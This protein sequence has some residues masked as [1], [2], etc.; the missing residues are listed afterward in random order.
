MT[1]D[2]KKDLYEKTMALL[3]PVLERVASDAAFRERLEQAPLAVLDELG[4]TIDSETRA[5]LE[6]K[7][8][9]EFWAARRRSVEGPVE[10]RDLPPDS[11]EDRQL[12]AVSGG[13]GLSVSLSGPVVNFAPPYVPVAPST[14]LLDVAPQPFNR[15]KF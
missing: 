9:S 7:R 10:I 8:F 12:D 4:I 11:L 6:G 2:P 15:N 3:K 14:G 1:A 5:E 13:A